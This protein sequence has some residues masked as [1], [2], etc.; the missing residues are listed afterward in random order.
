MAPVGL[1]HPYPR[2]REALPR[3]DPLY[4]QVERGADADIPEPRTSGVCVR[5]AL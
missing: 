2:E 5:V 1:L 4:V 3:Q